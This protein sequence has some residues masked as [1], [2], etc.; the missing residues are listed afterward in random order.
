MRCGYRTELMDHERVLE[1]IVGWAT[2]DDNIRVVVLTGSAAL[3]PEHV[4][5]LSDLDVE[6]YVAQPIMLLEDDAWHAQFGEVLVGYQPGFGSDSHGFW[7]YA[8]TLAGGARVLR[9]R[10]GRRASQ[11]R[12]GLARA[13]SAQELLLRYLPPPPAVVLDVGG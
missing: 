11:P 9:P 10:P 13:I 2:A 4:H 5:A 12:R 3:G 7:R 8:A 1:Q 6:L